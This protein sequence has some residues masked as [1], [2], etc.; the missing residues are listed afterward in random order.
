MD[1]LLFNVNPECGVPPVP[2]LDFKFVEDCVIPSPPP[3]IF[4]CPPPLPPPPEVPPPCPEISGTITVN[5]HSAGRSD[6]SCSN[7]S[8]SATGGITVTKTP[9]CEFLIDV[10]LDIPIP[11]PPCP[12]LKTNPPVVT[13]GYEDCVSSSSNSFT[14]TAT[15]TC[16]PE[17][18]CEFEFNL[19]LVIPIPRPPC[20]VINI[21][22]FKVET[23]Y[24]ECLTTEN[25]FTVSSSS[26]E[27]NCPD[28]PGQCSFDI[29]LELAIPIPKPPCPVINITTFTVESGYEECLTK[30]N[31]FEVT[32]AHKPPVCP[33]DPGECEFNIE[34]ELSIPVPKPPCPTIKAGPVTVTTSY[35]GCNNQQ[36]KISVTK[37]EQPP[38]CPN[39]PPTCEFEISLDL[40]VPIPKPPCPLLATAS[41]LEETL[42]PYLNFFIQDQSVPDPCGNGPGQC[43]FEFVIELGI[44]P[45]TCPS[46]WLSAGA[47]LL[48]MIEPDEEPEFKFKAIKNPDP[49][50]PPGRFT[51]CDVELQPYMKLPKN[52]VP[53]FQTIPATLENGRILLTDS[54]PRKEIFVTKLPPCKYVIEE[55]L[56]IPRTAKITKGD[57][58]ADWSTDCNGK[59]ELDVT[60]EEIKAVNGVVTEYKLHFDLKIPKFPRYIGGPIDLGPYGEGQINISEE[61][62]H[63]AIT[64]K[65]DLYTSNCGS[66]EGGGPQAFTMPIS[67]EPDQVKKPIQ[68]AEVRAYEYAGSGDRRR[69]INTES[70]W[71]DPKFMKQFMIQLKKNKQLR[72]LI[73]DVVAS[74]E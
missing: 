25:K 43:A 2:K 69:K 29:E 1:E 61:C 12:I 32:T 54:E 64:G 5:T 39:D 37:V 13:V 16:D 60:V 10:N 49:N 73:R 3:P 4:D 74:D 40:F 21:K 35:E 45:P 23:G 58:T 66:T 31:R 63:P 72:D 53:E 6:A 65:I 24:E 57:V 7:S 51:G 8:Q 59:P 19:E 15:P 56:W 11:Q 41:K 48:E 38:A 71:S 18:P 67:L 55:Y 44:P 30:Q 47:P 33:D 28:D 36:N 42:T 27:P 26:S 22:T 9:S 68:E 14:V 17:A 52:C 50:S 62:E 20:P 34:L 46:I 70:V